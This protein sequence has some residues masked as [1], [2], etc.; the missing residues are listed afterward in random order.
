MHRGRLKE[1]ALVFAF[2]VFFGITTMSFADQKTVGT[3]TEK[4]TTQKIKEEATDLSQTI[5]NYTIKQ[6]DDAVIKAK[7]A[8][9]DMDTRIDRM[10]NRI[11]E[12]WSQMDESARDKARATMKS[13]R[14]QRTEV[15]EWYGS[16]KQSSASA[17]K[18]VKKGFSKSYDDLKATFTKAESEY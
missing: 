11:A 17:W 9:V 13:L 18:D 6:K 16:M 5:K 8:L 2:A 14:K 12:K 7:D 15:A 3:E 10:E 1:A 4:T